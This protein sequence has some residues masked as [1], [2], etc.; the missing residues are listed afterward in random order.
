MI[1]W[2]SCAMDEV[3]LDGE[4]ISPSLSFPSEQERA[5]CQG[6]RFAK[7]RDEWLLGRWT[8]KQLL[9]RSLAEYKNVPLA[10]IAVANDPDGAPY[11]RVDGQRL[12]LCL[13]I[14]HRAGRALCALSGTHAVGADLERIEPREPAFV[15]DFFTVSENAQVRAASDVT[16]NLLVTLIWSAKE[17]ALKVLRQGLRIDTRKIEITF[18]ES[19][20]EIQMSSVKRQTST[21]YAIRNT[22]HYP[23]H[24]LHVEF[25]LPNAPRFAAW[26]QIDG[27]NVLTLVAAI[28]A[29]ST[30]LPDIRVA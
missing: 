18:D 14:S 8:A 12:P 29:G 11:Y 17:S 22:Q 3:P 4:G 16:R 10:E 19:L 23:W 6:F 27:P 15:E 1:Y 28:P 26:W 21:E 30:D 5:V 7:R 2:L 20:D 13:S 9:R 24:P 25:R